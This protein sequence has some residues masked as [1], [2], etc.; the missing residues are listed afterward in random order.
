MVFGNDK[1]IK[2][3]LHRMCSALLYGTTSGV[4]EGSFYGTARYGIATFTLWRCTVPQ[5]TR[6]SMKEP[7]LMASSH[8]LHLL[9]T[10]V[11]NRPKVH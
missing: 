6:S 10:A 7:L 1:S 3:R 2:V 5:C 11:I 8:L 9:R 4:N